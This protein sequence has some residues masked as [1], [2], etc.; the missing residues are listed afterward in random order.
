[1][2]VFSFLFSS[3]F[4]GGETTFPLAP[5]NIVATPEGKLISSPSP[6]NKHSRQSSAGSST[7][8]GEGSS[9]NSVEEVVH[10][11]MPECS[12]G[13]R[14]QPFGGGGALFYHKHG[15]GVNDELSSHGGCP[16][17]KEGDVSWKI[18][19]FMWNMDAN[20]GPM[21]YRE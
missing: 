2:C 8:S 6:L 1:M 12:K 14:I 13:L 11:G 3:Q 20:N 5:E 10:V 7:A 21:L 9:L 16:P 15:N 19:G 18:N 4:G 17:S